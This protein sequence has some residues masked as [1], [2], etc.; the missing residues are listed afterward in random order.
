MVVSHGT[1]S[2]FIHIQKTAGSSIEDALRSADPAIEDS[3]RDGRRHHFARDLRQAIPVEVWREY[4]KFAFVR[5]PWDRLVSWYAMC[6]R[7]PGS[8]RFSA[9]VNAVAPTFDDFLTR[10]TTGMGERTTWNQLD[11]VSD[12]DGRVIVD[13]I[14][15]Y[16]RLDE[17]F[18]VVRERLHL[19]R[20]LPHLNHTP[21]GEYRGYYS[22]ASREIVAQR[23]ARDIAH[24][25]YAF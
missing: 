11:Y 20:Q 16:E 21:H 8:N 10:A 3:L 2:V 13:F 5:N 9:Y 1:R 7:N 19:P 12:A 4:F 24:F 14:G 25:G 18:A 15:R 17:D 23:F 22:A 6:M